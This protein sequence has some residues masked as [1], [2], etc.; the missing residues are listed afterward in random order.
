MNIDYSQLAYKFLKSVPKKPLSEN[1]WYLKFCKII[2]FNH[3]ISVKIIFAE[4]SV[5]FDKFCTSMSY[6]IMSNV[7]DWLVIV[8]QLHKGVNLYAKVI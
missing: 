1:V 7:H 4:V 6:W 2:S 8:V 5:N 3:K